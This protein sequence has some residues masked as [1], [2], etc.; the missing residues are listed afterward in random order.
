MIE[1][2]NAV[3]GVENVPEGEAEQIQKI[4]DLMVELLEQRYR[5]GKQFL[6]GVH[7]KAHGCARATFT[8]NAERDLPNDF[9][10]GVFASPGASYEAVVRFSNAAALVGPDVQDFVNDRVKTRQHGSRGM[11]VKVRGLP[12]ISLTTDEPGTQDFLMVNFPVF[13]FANVADYLALTKAQLQHKDD[14]SLVF[15]TFAEQLVKSGGALRA[16]AAG[17]ISAAIQQTAMVDPLSSRYFSAAPFLFGSDRVMK[18]AVTP[19]SSTP[20]TPLPEVARQRLSAGCASK[21]AL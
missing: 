13:P 19:T 9:R 21:K 5:D 1:A 15:R 2:L 11:A 16:K 3:S 8:V 20:A 7:P 18:F 10:V 12:G 17:E 6:R 14:S 4:A